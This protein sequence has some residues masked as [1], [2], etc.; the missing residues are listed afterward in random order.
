M[1]NRISRSGTAPD[2]ATHRHVF[3][4]AAVALALAAAAFITMPKLETAAVSAT[5]TTVQTASN[6]APETAGCLQTWPY[7]EHSCLHDGRQ[8]DG[9]GHAVRLI[10]TGASAPHHASHH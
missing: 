6:A 10:T 2:N 9:D 1:S 4:C 7:Y 5:D 3:H 8:Q